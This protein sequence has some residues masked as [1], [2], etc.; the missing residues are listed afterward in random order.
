[1]GLLKNKILIIAGIVLLLGGCAWLFLLF[2]R[3]K[4]PV[5]PAVNAVPVNAFCVIHSEHIR[6]TFKSLTQGNLLWED[7]GVTRIIGT[8]DKTGRLIDSLLLSPEEQAVF[9]NNP[10]WLSLHCTG[11]DE[12]N[13]FFSISLPAGTD[14]ENVH[15][16][17]TQAAGGKKAREEKHGKFIVFKT[18]AFTYA[19]HEGILLLSDN[20][21]LTDASLEQMEKGLSLLKDKGFSEVMNTAGSKADANIY[22]S[23]E[24]LPLFIKRSTRESFASNA[25]AVSHFGGWTETDLALRPNALLLN[26]FTSASDTAGDFLATFRN[27]EP[28]PFEMVAVVPQQSSTI[29]RYGFGDFASFYRSYETYL[30]KNGLGAERSSSIMGMNSQYRIDIEDLL[31]S[32]VGDEIALVST[33]WPGNAEDNNF[34]VIEAAD[35]KMAREKLGKLKYITDYIDREATSSADMLPDTSFYGGYAIRRIGILHMVPVVYGSVFANLSNSY[36]CIIDRYVIFANKP[37]SLQSFILSY[38]NGKTLAND[39]LYRDFASNLPEESNIF[40]YTAPRKSLDTYRQF[41]SPGVTAQLETHA[42]LLGKMEGLGVQFTVKN[43]LFYTSAYLR[44]NNPEAKQEA[45]SLWEIALD[46]SF[47]FRPQLVLNHNTKAMDI[48][49]QDDAHTLYL[50]SNTGKIWWKRE[51]SEPVTSPVQQVDALKNGKLQLVFS[52]EKAIWVI[53]RNGKDLDGFPLRLPARA[54][55]PLCVFDYE[56]NREYRMLIPCSDKKIY[57]YTIK[58]KPVEGWKMDATQEEVTAPVRHAMVNGKDYL[59]IADKGGK[60]YV[61]DRQGRTRLTLKQRLPA[62]VGYFVLEPGKDLDRT[63]IVA[64]DSTG[65]FTRVI[66]NDSPEIFDPGESAAVTG[67]DYC[68]INGD[69]VYEYLLQENNRLRVFSQDKKQLWSFLSEQPLGGQ[70]LQL[71]LQNKDCRIGLVVPANGEIHLLNGNGEESIGFPVS[72]NTS[73]SVGNLNNDGNMVL[74][75]GGNSKHL[76]AY[77]VK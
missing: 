65:K 48:F 7:L 23:C 72:G 1:M 59:V 4:T 25:E 24:R 2:S 55:G 42:E 37:E 21:A 41:A 15:A 70:L 47:H 10:A 44:R 29:L 36:Y 77:P 68:D 11:N 31:T 22:V 39:K 26:G 49:V 51:F 43:G 8:A 58:G 74:V 73:F 50:I 64:A 62:P 33:D 53:D 71:H 56:K 63:R 76:Y 17:I 28:R 9:E 35:V 30:E 75:C 16:F 69:D 12:L 60:L 13:W 54:S 57:N 32:W 52:T 5:Q 6:G 66:M 18:D 19:L 27:Q 45:N 34:A 67:F 61:V 20:P 38:E 14:E 40:I 46:T 3:S